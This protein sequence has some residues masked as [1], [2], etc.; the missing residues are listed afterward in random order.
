EDEKGKKWTLQGHSFNDSG[1][2]E[3]SEG[4]E[5]SLSVDEPIFTSLGPVNQKGRIFHFTDAK[6]LGNLAEH[7]DVIGTDD[8]EPQLRI[9]S[10]DG[11]YDRS[12][13]F[14]YG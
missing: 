10:E 9:R 11:S 3:V 14:E 12:F 1:I 2:F 5:T 7:I 8:G 4:A 6:V 13:T